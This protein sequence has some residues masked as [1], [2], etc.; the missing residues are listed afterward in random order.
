MDIDPS[1]LAPALGQ[2]MFL[3]F[4]MTLL[5]L[6][7][8]A[9]TVRASP[10]AAGTVSAQAPRPEQERPV[11]E[12]R[13]AVP[14]PPIAAPGGWSALKP[15]HFGTASAGPTS[16]RREEPKMDNSKDLKDDM[17]K[18]VRYWVSYEKRGFE[19]VLFDGI[20]HVY[21]NLT[22]AQFT[23]WKMAEFMDK[24]RKNQIP[25]KGDL[26]PQKID[27]ADRKYLTIDWEVVGRVERRKGWFDDR[28]VRALETIAE[29][30]GE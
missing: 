27:D 24:L 9:R 19:T 8:L 6:N 7:L 16:T 14:A 26:D 23:S 18:T 20:D 30:I 28:Q 11:P 5:G 13:P 17:L 29:R 2:L 3:P 10:V 21:D 12:A 15:G 1:G 25:K 4:S 22:D